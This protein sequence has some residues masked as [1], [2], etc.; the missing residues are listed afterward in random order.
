MQIEDSR[1]LWIPFDIFEQL[2]K[3]GAGY[4]EQTEAMCR[5]FMQVEEQIIFADDWTPL[6]EKYLIS[7]G[8]VMPKSVTNIGGDFNFELPK[9]EHLAVG[10]LQACWQRINGRESSANRKDSNNV[11]ITSKHEIVGN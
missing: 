8:H 11:I 6:F 1:H 5:V 9:S 2:A 10:I 7:H 4:Q 3:S